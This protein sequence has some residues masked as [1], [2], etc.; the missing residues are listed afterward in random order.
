MLQPIEP[1]SQSFILTILT[2]YNN[3][4]IVSIVYLPPLAHKLAKDEN[5][6]SFYSLTSIPSARTVDAQ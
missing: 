4:L 3:L 2:Y 5:I 6:Y 1:S